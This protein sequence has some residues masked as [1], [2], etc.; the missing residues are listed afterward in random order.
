MPL[1]MVSKVSK[2]ERPREAAQWV[3]KYMTDKETVQK[4]VHET[5]RKL[6]TAE[7]TQHKQ[8]GFESV[9]LN[10]MCNLTS[11]R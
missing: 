8:R 6:N 5:I 3:Q 2:C 9:I 4:K 10:R 7:N 1:A 11:S